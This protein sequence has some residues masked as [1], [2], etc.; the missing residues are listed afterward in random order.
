M[1]VDALNIGDVGCSASIPHTMHN[2]DY[3]V[4]SL[5]R[6]LQFHLRFDRRNTR[7]QYF[8][9]RVSDFTFTCVVEARVLV[10]GTVESQEGYWLVVKA[11]YCNR[12]RW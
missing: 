6:N 12:A 8:H 2:L 9:I 5:R 3:I 10:G 4:G 7:A 11:S 1:H